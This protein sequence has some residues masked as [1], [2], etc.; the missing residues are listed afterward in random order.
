MD[1]ILASTS[2]YRKAQLLNMGYNVTSMPSH[3]DENITKNKSANPVEIAETLSLLKAESIL[4]SKPNQ[5]IIGGD[6]LIS[7]DNKIIGKT[8]SPEKAAQQIFNFSGKTHQII[9]SVC[10]LYKD[11]KK[12]ITEISEM[13]MKTMTLQEAKAYVELDKTWDCAG[14]YK[15]ELNGKSLF[16]EIKTNDLSS[17]QGIPEI[18]LKSYLASLV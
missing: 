9:T 2:P 10:V 12:I 6:Q 7:F 8:G 13:T 17:I 3:I 16:S 15:I 18:K 14:S 11:T 4:A 1:I 5:I